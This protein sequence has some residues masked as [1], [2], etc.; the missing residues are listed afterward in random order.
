MCNL[1]QISNDTHAN[2]SL[3]GLSDDHTT[4]VVD[5]WSRPQTRGE[6]DDLVIEAIPIQFIP[7]DTP[8]KSSPRRTTSPS[9][10]SPSRPQSSKASPTKPK[11]PHRQVASSPSPPTVLLSVHELPPRS[12]NK[13]IPPEKYFD[14]PKLSKRSLSYESLQKEKKI[15]SKLFAIKASQ[16]ASPSNPQRVTSLF[17]SEKIAFTPDSRGKGKDEYYLNMTNKSQDILNSMMDE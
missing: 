2:Q 8:T 15:Q 13:K 6:R 5:T 16:V 10:T 14:S 1:N 7:I 4:S 3:E 11:V 12:P 17:L 9:S